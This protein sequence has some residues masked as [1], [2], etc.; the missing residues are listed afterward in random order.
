LTS[1]NKNEPSVTWAFD[2]WV[3]I[4][5]NFLLKLEGKSAYSSKYVHGEF[6]YPCQINFVKFFITSCASFSISSRR[7]KPVVKNVKLAF[8]LKSAWDKDYKYEKKIIFEQLV[9]EN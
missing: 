2:N 7:L 6:F 4:Q 8:N 1:W 5:K 3:R 9:T